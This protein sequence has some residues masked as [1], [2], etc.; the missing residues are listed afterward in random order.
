MIFLF[1]FFGV[2]IKWKSDEIVSVWAKMAKVSS[3]E[4][5]RETSADFEACDHGSISMEDLW[6]RIGA[7]YAIPPFA[8][9]KAFRDRFH[10]RAKL[11]DDVVEVVQELKKQSKV[12]LFS[13]QWPIHALICREKGWFDFFDKVFLSYELKACKPEKESFLAVLKNIKAQPNECIL[14]DDKEKNVAG[15]VA[16]G[17][18]GIVFK[19]ASQLRSDLE[20]L[21]NISISK[22]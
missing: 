15:A 11:D 2:V 10:E 19:S 1:D 13:N 5:R 16:L 4:F 18:K 8:V 6:I 7:K 12:Y 14:I 22:V 20:K 17:M 21:Y 9:G 3:E